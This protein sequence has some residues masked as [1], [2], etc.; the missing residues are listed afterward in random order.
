MRALRQGVTADVFCSAC[1]RDAASTR[2]AF[3]ES[4]NLERAAGGKT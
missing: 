1:T 2:K 3:K 4:D